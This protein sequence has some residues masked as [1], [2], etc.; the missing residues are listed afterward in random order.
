VSHLVYAAGREH[1]TH[2]WI[3]GDLLV[4]DRELKSELV[5]AFG[6]LD[7]LWHIWQNALK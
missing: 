2:V 7:T 1:V 5:S 4:R 3:D 6:G